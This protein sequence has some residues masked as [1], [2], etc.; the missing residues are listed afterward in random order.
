MMIG[1]DLPSHHVEHSC[2][3][4]HRSIGQFS[5]HEQ[6]YKGKTSRVYT[7]TDKLS[8]L[9]VVIKY[10]KK[11]RLTPLNKVSA[12]MNALRTPSEP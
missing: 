4:A 1:L 2:D 11:D 3:I 5:L 10:Y 7:A 8:L 12:L 9:H 6:I